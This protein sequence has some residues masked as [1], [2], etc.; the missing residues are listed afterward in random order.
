MYT[1]KTIEQLY[2]LYLQHPVVSTDTRNLPTGCI[3]FALK[4]ANFDGNFFATKAIEAGA[5]CAVVDDPDL[6]GDHLF[7]V[8]NVLEALQQL[9]LFH[10]RHFEI[11]IIAIGGSNGK[12]T[13]KELVSAVLSSHY[14]CHFTK[15]N[16]N[17]HIG[18]PLTLLSMP[19]DTEVAVIEMGTNQP[20]D[21]QELCD[22]TAPTHG[23]LTNIGKEHLEG[24]GN[25]EGVKKAEAELYHYL[26]RH[27]GCIFLNLSEKYL[28]TLARHNKRKV[29]Y[30]QA[31][32][33]VA[34]PGTI[35]IQLTQETPFITAGFTSD[36]GEWILVESQ[37]I[38][39]HNFQ[40]IMTAIALG[41]YFKVPANK[42]KAAIETYIPS[43]NRSQLLRQGST[44]IL[45]DAYNANPSSMIPAL[46]TM[47]QF[48]AKRKIAILGDML[49][50]GADSDKEHQ[51]ILR[52]AARMKPDQLVLVGTEFGKT[53][54]QKYK[55]LHFPKVE[56]AREWFLTQNTA[57]CMIL[58]K[59]S[60]GIRLE[61]ILGKG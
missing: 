39:K 16:F 61:K 33:T 2:Q 34:A 3:F 20:G 24:F 48:P 13:T 18:V 7:L 42:I 55:A 31:G 21:L 37:L 19:D 54:Y 38:G 15:G 8:P 46:Q 59:G 26:S 51:A 25:L 35:E 23:L 5:A 49:E 1:L 47:Q 41:I 28:H 22:I 14:P 6:K 50:L 40:N 44:T 4:G 52:F 30:Q 53:P 43:N 58:V 10:R 17:N 57:D 9:A 36:A 56:E 60:R 27:K 45:L 11:P 32:T 29:V 12:T